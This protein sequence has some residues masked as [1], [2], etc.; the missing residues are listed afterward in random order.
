MN[1][2][3]VLRPRLDTLPVLLAAFQGGQAC[4]QAIVEVILGV[5]EPSGRLP[6]SF[7]V[8]AEVLPVFYSRKPSAQRGGYCDVS[9]SVRWP[10]GYGLAYTTFTLSNFT[11][12]SVVPAAGV[13]RVNVTVTNS[14]ERV[15]ESYRIIYAL[16]LFK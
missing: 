4:G 15:G 7:P 5:T 16:L 2:F 3:M 10:F 6:I 11:V 13:L 1:Y 14:G 8:S 9:S 12:P